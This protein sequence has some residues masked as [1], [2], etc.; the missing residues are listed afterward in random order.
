MEFQVE[1]RN[2]SMRKAWQDKIE[3]EKEK[4][5]RHHPGL[6]HTLRVTIENTSSHKEGGFEV[7]VV[8][9][10]PND[11]VVVKRKGEAV[12]P[13]LV[14]GFDTLGLQLKELQRRRRQTSKVPE[15]GRATAGQGTIKSIFAEQAYGFLITPEGRDIYFHA[16]ALKDVGI[17]QL[18]VGDAIRFGEGEGDMG[19]SAAWVKVA[20]K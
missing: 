20:G 1:A 3:E 8:A 13:L 15:G 2:V 6:V 4:L 10:V 9:L 5:N 11:T 12:K 19:P 17:D 18:A 16:N 14:E 7:R